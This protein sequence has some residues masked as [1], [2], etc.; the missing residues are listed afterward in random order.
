M[1]SE[2]LVYLESSFDRL[3][4]SLG[5]SLP[6]RTRHFTDRVM[7][8]ASERLMYLKLCTFHRCLDQEMSKPTAY[9]NLWSTWKV[10]KDKYTMLV[11]CVDEWSTGTLNCQSTDREW[12][13]MSTQICVVNFI[14]MN[15]LP[16]C[17]RLC[18]RQEWWRW[19]WKCLK[20]ESTRK[21]TPIVV[22]E[23]LWLCKARFNRWIW[24]D[25]PSEAWS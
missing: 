18:K 3:T 11:D 4:R 15:Y 2:H 14:R 6:R 23:M 21:S 9:P 7:L 24:P 5:S 10:V 20:Y 22:Q 13:T 16:S 8:Y 19:W 17:G 25:H 1:R 12:L